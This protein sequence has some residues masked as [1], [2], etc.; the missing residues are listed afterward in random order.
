MILRGLR[1]GAPCNAGCTRAR[2]EEVNS[3]RAAVH[4]TLMEG[5]RGTGSVLDA[6]QR[7]T[8]IWQL[9]NLS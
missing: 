9:A 4:S 6:R 1:G 2:G 5:W 8:S 3:S 7:G